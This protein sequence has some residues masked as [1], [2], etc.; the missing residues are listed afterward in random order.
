M[1]YMIV[2]AVFLIGFALA[3]AADAR[4]KTIINGTTGQVQIVPLTPQEETEA[5]AREANYQAHLKTALK[6]RIQSELERRIGLVLPRDRQLADVARAVQLL[7]K[8]SG[9]W[10]VGERAEAQAFR[11]KQTSIRALRAKAVTL[12]GSLDAMTLDQLKAFSPRADANW[13]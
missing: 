7:D 1:T 8:G 12:V 6:R 3:L 5:D 2:L 13:Q 9:T 10:T 11:D 4:T